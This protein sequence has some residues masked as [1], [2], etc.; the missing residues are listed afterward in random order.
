MVLI[1]W[2]Q[3]IVLGLKTI[4][5]IYFLI[6]IVN[7]YQFLNETMVEVPFGAILVLMAIIILR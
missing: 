6:F 5:G 7:N 2:L 3:T 4:I 1:D